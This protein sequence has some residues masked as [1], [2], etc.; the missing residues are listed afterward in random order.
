M[1]RPDA[2]W[3]NFIIIY[4]MKIYVSLSAEIERFR[5]YKDWRSKST[6]QNFRPCYFRQYV[7]GIEMVS[8]L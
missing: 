2:I 3:N 8:C 6:H 4:N 1:V 5:L 7:Y